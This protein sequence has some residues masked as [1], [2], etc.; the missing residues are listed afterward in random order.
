MRRILTT[1]FITTSIVLVNALPAL[2]GYA[3]GN[4]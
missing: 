4:G 2:A 1:A 3:N